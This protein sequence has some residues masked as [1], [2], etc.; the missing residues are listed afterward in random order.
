MGELLNNK[1]FINLW[2][3]KTLEVCERSNILGKRA[4][5]FCEQLSLTFSFYE[6]GLD[7]YSELPVEVN[8]PL[9]KYAEIYPSHKGGNIDFLPEIIHHHGF[10]ED[11]Y[12]KTPYPIIQREVDKINNDVSLIISSK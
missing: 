8:F 5:R 9:G 6:Y 3:V 2:I 11:I 1:E 7:V 10:M 12:L 4:K